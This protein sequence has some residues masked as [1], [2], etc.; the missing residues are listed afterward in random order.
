MELGSATE[1]VMQIFNDAVP[2]KKP[3][4]TLTLKEQCFGLVFE[5]HIYSYL[6]SGAQIPKPFNGFGGLPTC[7]YDS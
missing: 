1:T 3:M 4:L 6:F 5:K 7:S 2:R